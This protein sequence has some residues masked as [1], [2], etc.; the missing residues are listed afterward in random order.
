MSNKIDCEV[1]IGGKVYTLSGYESEEYLQRVAS[2]L[3]G[4][5]ADFSKEAGYTRLPLDLQNI[6]MQINI[7]DDYFKARNEIA[8]L[9]EDVE[10]KEKD[11]YDLKH[12]LIAAQMKLENTEKNYRALQTENNENAKKMIRIETELKNA[13]EPHYDRNRDR[14]RQ[15]GNQQHTHGREGGSEAD[16]GNTENEG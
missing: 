15:S 1:V 6:L 10:A 8:L 7:A 3:N 14:N 16:K 9:E 4:K 11:L 12:E 2:Y 13:R 5:L